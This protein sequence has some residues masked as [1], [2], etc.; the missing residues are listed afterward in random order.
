[1]TPRAATIAGS[2]SCGGAGIQA[3][4]KT[5][6]AFGV[7]GMSV[8]TA[9][10]AQNTMGVAGIFGLDSEFVRLQW[11]SVFSD[12]GA[13]GVKTG[14][15][16]DAD[17]IHA[18]AEELKQSGVPWVVVDPVM[19]AKDGSPLLQDRAVLALKQELIPI[20]SLV[21]PNIS[22]AEVLS[23]MKITN[24]SDMESAARKIN[25]IGCHAV[26]V[27]GGHLEGD[28]S[29]VLFDGNQTVRFPGN[30][31][32]SR[33]VH[34]TG[35]TFSAAIL[36]NLILGKSLEDSIRISKAYVEEAIRNG[37]TFGTGAALLNHGVR[38][39]EPPK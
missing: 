20:A 35:C 24:V 17:I 5:F 2:D 27:K 28:P 33:P 22:E 21:T 9:V 37:F 16:F 30:R 26:L 23:G 12:M 10:T 39:S 11:R 13:D 25:G 15:L 1:L 31:I 38:A 8:I 3:D 14:M 7:F 18:V 32:A 4:L 29:D 19:L 6:S 34:G 36:A